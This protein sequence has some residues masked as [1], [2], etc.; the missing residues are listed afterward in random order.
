MSED[1]AMKRLFCG[2]LALCLLA[3]VCAGCTQK[4][5]PTQPSTE[6]H[7]T[8]ATTVPP[9]TVTTPPTTVPVTLEG[10]TVVLYTANIRGDLSV[11]SAIW[12]TKLAY[13]AQGATVYLCCKYVHR[14]F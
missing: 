13:E 8:A 9:T 3:A 7:T 10:A 6:N 4:P 11:Y 12:A 5:V 2:L 1:H 14:G